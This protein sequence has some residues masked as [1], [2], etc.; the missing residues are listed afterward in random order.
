MIRTIVTIPTRYENEAGEK[1]DSSNV[2]RVYS[3]FA[4]DIVR[5]KIGYITAQGSAR[6]VQDGPLVPGPWAYTYPLSSAIT[7]DP[8]H[9]TAAESERL[10]SAGVEWQVKVGDLFVMDGHLWQLTEDRPHSD[11]PQLTLI[12]EAVITEALA[13]V[14]EK[15]AEDIHQPT[16][17]PMILAQHLPEE[18]L[19]LVG[20]A[21]LLNVISGRWD[22]GDLWGSAMEVGFAAA[23]ALYSLGELERVPESMQYSPGVWDGTFMADDIRGGGDNELAVQL[24]TYMDQDSPGVEQLVT[25]LEA[26]DTLLERLKAEGQ[27]Y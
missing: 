18:Y 5:M 15:E 20:V 14:A 4:R 24:V 26:T 11:Y 27:D 13:P 1:L 19:E 8:R 16:G 2:L 6:K 10:T 9:S 23:G 25:V 3:K 22:S 7:A 12:D 17:L 21:D